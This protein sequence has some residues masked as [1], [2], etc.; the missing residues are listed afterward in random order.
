MIYTHNTILTND[1]FDEAYE[2]NY[3]LQDE[4]MTFILTNND[5][6]RMICDGDSLIEAQEAGYMYEEF[7]AAYI[8]KAMESS[9]KQR[10]R[11][12]D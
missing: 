1:Q 10:A 7:R 6:T 8:L 11:Y 9:I 3:D 12:G 5:G 4:H 2:S